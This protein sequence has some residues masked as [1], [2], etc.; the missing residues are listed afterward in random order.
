MT[1]QCIN[2]CYD[3]LITYIYNNKA[4]VINNTATAH[5]DNVARGDCPLPSQAGKFGGGQLAGV[6]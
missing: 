2:K 3:L 6:N 1:T 5:D 4:N